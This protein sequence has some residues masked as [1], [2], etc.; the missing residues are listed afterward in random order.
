[1]GADYA[2]LS[3]I[4]R[5][6]ALSV[7]EA[8]NPFILS[9]IHHRLLAIELTDIVRD[10]LWKLQ[11]CDQSY[12]DQAFSLFG[13]WVNVDRNIYL[14]HFLKTGAKRITLSWYMESLSA[15]S[16][17]WKKTEER[18]RVKD[19]TYINGKLLDRQIDANAL[20]LT[21]IHSLFFFVKTPS[22]V[23]LSQELCED[24]IRTD[25]PDEIIDIEWAI[26]CGILAIPDAIDLGD[27]KFITWNET[28]F[29]DDADSMEKTVVAYDKHGE[30]RAICDYNF[31]EDGN[32]KHESPELN[33]ILNF[34]AWL[35]LYP[36]QLEEQKAKV[37]LAG[38]KLSP[39]KLRTLPL[40]PIHFG[41]NYQRKT[42]GAYKGGTHASPSMHWRRGHWVNQACGKNWS[43]RRPIWKRPILVNA[44]ES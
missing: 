32:P 9:A 20:I 35:N 31:S 18:M 5:S 6:A 10:E 7:I 38:K 13:F 24:L 33:L 14:E 23:T 4:R 19:G 12:I 30:T 40:R 2:D 36:E 11:G 17:V 41:E 26:P 44:K 16:H 27:T 25:A 21:A 29:H 37:S 22:V 1:L 43:E 42:S 39:K 3:V 28:R 15:S 34:L 8:I